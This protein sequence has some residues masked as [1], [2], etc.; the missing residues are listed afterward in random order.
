[1]SDETQDEVL[2]RYRNVSGHP[3]D[4]EDGRVVGY[5]G[6]DSFVYFSEEDLESDFNKAKIE[7]GTF[8]ESPEP[9][10]PEPTLEDLQ[11][12]AREL[13]VSGRS[14]MKKEELQQA[15][16]EAETAANNAT[17]GDG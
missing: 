7:N 8:I 11:Q 14:S 6:D 1:V 13:D 9:E 3:E 15:I 5:L 10:N 12:K 16:A 17:G 4:T 2:V